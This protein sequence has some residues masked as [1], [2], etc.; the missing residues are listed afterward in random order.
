LNLSKINESPSLIVRE[1]ACPAERGTRVGQKGLKNFTGI[2]YTELLAKDGL[3]GHL[4]ELQF[5]DLARE[6]LD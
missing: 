1:P 3:Y 2:Y 5:R 6:S 4:Y